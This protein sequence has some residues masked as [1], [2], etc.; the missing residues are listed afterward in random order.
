[1]IGI[2]GMGVAYR[3]IPLS[4]LRGL[5]ATGMSALNEVDKQLK[6]DME[7]AASTVEMDDDLKVQFY[8]WLA[9]R[10]RDGLKAIPD[11]DVE[12]SKDETGQA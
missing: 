2:F 3:S 7:R 4:S 12:R 1:L 6:L 8:Q 10:G 5:K 9:Q 11:A